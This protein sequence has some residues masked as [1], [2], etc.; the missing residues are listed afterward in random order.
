MRLEIEAGRLDFARRRAG[1]AL[2]FLDAVGDQHDAVVLALQR[3]E[4]ARR[5]AQR[6]GD[7]CFTLGIGGLDLGVDGGGIVGADRRDQLDVLAVV[8]AAVA[9]HQQAEPDAG[10]NFLQRLV[11]RLLGGSHARLGSGGDLHRAGGVED[12]EDVVLRLGGRRGH[13]ACDGNGKPRGNTQDG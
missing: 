12:E 6:L 2:A 1:V 7:R 10:G 3:R 5:L 11:H 8:G 4:A 13:S 9:V